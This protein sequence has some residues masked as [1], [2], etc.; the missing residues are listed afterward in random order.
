[1]FNNN[2]GRI[3]FF[4]F[5]KVIGPRPLARTFGFKVSFMPMPLCLILVF[6]CGRIVICYGP[7]NNDLACFVKFCICNNSLASL[8]FGCLVVMWIHLFLVINFLNE[9]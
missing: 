2:F 5:A 8:I 7:K 9:T 1:M 3:W 6:S 4:I